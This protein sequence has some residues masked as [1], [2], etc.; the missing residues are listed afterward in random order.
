MCPLH[1]NE[2]TMTHEKLSAILSDIKILDRQFEIT[3]IVIYDEGGPGDAWLLQVTYEEP[4]VD[5]GVVTTQRSR[6]WLIR[7]SMSESEVVRTAYAAVTRSYMHV[8]AE[9]FTYKGKRVFGP[10][11]DIDALLEASERVH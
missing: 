8:V 6:E 4:D 2:E 9:N 11:V 7:P 1:Y 5:T 3:P 10:H